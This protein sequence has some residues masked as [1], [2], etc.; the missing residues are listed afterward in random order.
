[1]WQAGSLL[2][3][4]KGEAFPDRCVMN[5]RPAH[6]RRVRQAVECGHSVSFLV[7]ILASVAFHMFVPLGIGKSYTFTVGL[8][9]ECC[10]K[11]RRAFWVAGGVI[12]AAIA[13]TAY[14]LKLLTEGETSA[15]IWMS[16]LGILSILGGLLYG[17]N[18]STL[19]TAP[20]IST[21]YVWLRGAHPDFLAELPV[22]PGES[23]VEDGRPFYDDD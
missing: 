22:W 6:G 18:A 17:L 2:V 4:R 13:T 7:H 5:N 1:M 20:R 9:E 15:G 8:C 11:R 12:A 3:V 19:M 21:D 16:C 10:Q 14:S 23:A